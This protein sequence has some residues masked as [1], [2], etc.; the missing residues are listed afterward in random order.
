M[1]LE[2]VKIIEFISM[3]ER[4]CVRGGTCILGDGPI[5]SQ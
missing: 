3:L 2:N 1:K 5:T 4:A